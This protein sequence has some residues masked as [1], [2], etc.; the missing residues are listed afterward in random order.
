MEN[1]RVRGGKDLLQFHGETDKR[2]VE[3]KW[4]N[5]YTPKERSIRYRDNVPPWNIQKTRGR[6]RANP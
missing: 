6:H 4:R 5:N 2:Y 1:E 3:K